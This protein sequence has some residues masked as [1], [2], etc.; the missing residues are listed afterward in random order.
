M[1]DTV[2]QARLTLLTVSIIAL[3]VVSVADYLSAH[4]TPTQLYHLWWIDQNDEAQSVLLGEDELRIPQL[5]FVARSGERYWTVHQESSI[6]L[7]QSCG[8]DPDIKDPMIPRQAKRLPLLKPGVMQDSFSNLFDR[9]CHAR[10]VQH[11][12][13][14]LYRGYSDALTHAGAVDVKAF[15]T[16]KSY[17]GSLTRDFR[18]VGQ[19]GHLVLFHICTDAYGCGAHGNIQCQAFVLNLEDQSARPHL[20]VSYSAEVTSLERPAMQRR[21]TEVLET[22]GTP[23]SKPT[24]IG[25]EVTIDD[26]GHQQ[27]HNMWGG[28]TCYVCSHG[29]WSS[30]TYRFDTPLS[31]EA[32]SSLPVRLESTPKPVRDFVRAQRPKALGWTAIDPA[33]SAQIKSW[34]LK[35]LKPE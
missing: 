31:R 24:W 13:Y 19:I 2:Y 5:T 7:T 16:P 33:H 9:Q 23:F 22:S 14:R 12:E 25:I 6:S 20:D 3:S 4:P 32:R 35:I 8:C 10:R 1:E 34:F 27:L 15:I 21:Y 28:D 29:D 26:E 18:W 11:Q 17:F 30:Y